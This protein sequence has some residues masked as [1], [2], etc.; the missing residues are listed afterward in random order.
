MR[1]YSV[2]IIACFFQFIS[3]NTFAQLKMPA[4]RKVPVIEN[5]CGVKV[6]DDYRW[7]ENLTDP[8]VKDWFKAQND[9]TNQVLGQIAGRDSLINTL[10]NYDKLQPARYGTVKSRAGRYFFRKTLPDENVSKLY[11]KNGDNGP[12]VM[13]FDPLHYGKGKNYSMADYIPSDNG[14]LIA[15]AIASGGGEISFIRIYNLETRS[16]LPDSIGPVREEI[17]WTP[18]NKG[19]IYT[20]LNSDNPFDANFQM[21]TASRYHAIGTNQ[22]NDK[23]LL[24]AAKYPELNISRTEVP[25]VSFTNN[26]QYLLGQLT[27]VDLRTHVVI[28]PAGDLLKIRISWRTLITRED[29]VVQAV[30]V[31]NQLL[32]H[33]IKSAPNGRILTTSLAQPNIKTAKVV[34]PEDKKIYEIIA[35]KDYLLITKDDVVRSYLQTYHVPT[36]TLTNVTQPLT[37]INAFGAY[38]PKTNDCYVLLVSW[39]QPV[40]TYSYQADKKTIEISPFSSPARYPGLNDLVVEEIE[41]PGHDGVQVPLSIIYRKDLKKDGSAVCFMTGYGAYGHSAVPHFDGKYLAMLNKGVVVAVTHPRGGSEKGLNWYKAGFKTTKPNTWKDFISSGEYL[42]KNGYTSA[43]HLIGEGTSAGGI[44][45][46]R[47]I[48]ERPDLFAAAINNVGASNILRFELTPNADNI[49]E[50]GTFKD[51]VECKALL[52]MD[53]YLHVKP[54]TKYPAVINVGGMNDPRVIVWQPG[55]FAAA[56]QNASASGKPVLMQ[57]NYDNGHFTEEKS[58]TFRN[59]ANMYAFAL[60]QAGHPDFKL[61]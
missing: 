7:L 57:V 4:T 52:E 60:W 36:G 29:S 48:T 28:A 12:E 19:L 13:M 51:S 24:S 35:S 42:I 11:Y 30:A 23:V 53:A 37:G 16:F 56:L 55:K 20:R 50:F 46:G 3:L 33:S 26:G 8:A 45:I 10:V 15:I 41:I 21:N 18:D 5:Y 61:K 49:A 9:Y 47:A 39:L 17:A 2:L 14:K 58:V 25:G 22:I 43:N 6:T 40:V 1:R 54:G 31:G 32:L 44:L 34:V 59:F 27:T 38:D